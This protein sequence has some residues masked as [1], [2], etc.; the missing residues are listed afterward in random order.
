MRCEGRHVE[1]DLTSIE[2]RMRSKRFKYLRYGLALATAIAMSGCGAHS[3][4]TPP[5]TETSN[6][7]GA[8]GQRAGTSMT[9]RIADART[10]Q[11]AKLV[12]IF[13]N[14][15]ASPS[16]PYWGGVQVVIVGG[17]G[18][19]EFPSTQIAAAF[20]PSASASATEVEVAAVTPSLPGYEGSGFTLSVN[21]DDKGVPGKALI[22]AQLPDLPSD[23]P[24]CCSLIVGKVPH[25]LSLKADKQ[26][27]VVISGQ[28]AQ[29]GNAA[30][31]TE[32]ATDQVHPFLDAVYC[33]Y[34]PNCQNGAGWYAFKGDDFGSGL[35]FAVLG[36]AN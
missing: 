15:G 35:A 22:T 1:R 16:G 20:T 8:L 29:S 4:G 5:L 11:D 17:S 33:S 3:G 6:N 13:D 34:A 31:W 27:W 32:E 2:V 18:N 23:P 9:V 19:S 7:V 10:V 24:L 26:Y 12:K 25:G 30:G 14:L 36:K 28:S 21:V